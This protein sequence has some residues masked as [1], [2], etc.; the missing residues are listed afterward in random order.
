MAVTFDDAV[1]L[2]LNGDHLEVFHL[3]AAHTDG[4][5]SLVVATDTM[6]NTAYAFA[7]KITGENAA[8][9]F[10]FEVPARY[11]AEGVPGLRHRG[12]GQ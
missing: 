11:R 1:T 2:H 6:K 9:F 12:R 7:A 10:K 8:R 5:N 4:D 3:S